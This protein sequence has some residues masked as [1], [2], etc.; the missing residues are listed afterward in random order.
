MDIDA[1]TYEERGTLMKEG[2]CFNC[3]NVG[4]LAKDCPKKDKQKKKIGGKE[5][6]AHIR[7]L[8]KDMDENE[9]EMFLNEAEEAG[10]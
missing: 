6:H 3:R 4:H 5:L 10:F 1:L 2:K 9:K 7:G 8:M